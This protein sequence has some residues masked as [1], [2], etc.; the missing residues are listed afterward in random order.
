LTEAAN[1]IFSRD[2]MAWGLDAL[3]SRMQTGSRGHHYDGGKLH[4]FRECSQQQKARGVY[5]DARQTLA[6]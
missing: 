5:Y 1:A 3:A 4:Y 2:A 6:I